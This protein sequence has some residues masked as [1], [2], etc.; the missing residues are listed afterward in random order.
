VLAYL[1]SVLAGFDR[2]PE[3]SAFVDASGF[4]PGAPE[5]EARTN[6]IF[7]PME[8]MRNA[9]EREVMVGDQAVRESTARAPS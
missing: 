6:E 7:K 5:F 2:I 4:K 1:P 9:V 8:A 3:F